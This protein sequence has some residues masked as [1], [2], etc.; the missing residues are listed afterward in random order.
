MD[1]YWTQIYL[2]L[3]VPYEAKCFCMAGTTGLEPATSA[4][5]GHPEGVSDCKQGATAGTFGALGSSWEAL[6]DPYWTHVLCRNDLCRRPLP[7]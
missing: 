3:E 2:S 4:V 6:L 5:T 7:K 1:P